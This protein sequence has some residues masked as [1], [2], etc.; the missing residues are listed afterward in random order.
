MRGST[1]PTTSRDRSY[2]VNPLVGGTSIGR[3]YS[4]VDR[5]IAFIGELHERQRQ[6]WRR[7]DDARRRR[8]ATARPRLRSRGRR[9]RRAARVSERPGRVTA[10]AQ[11]E[12]RNPGFHLRARAR[13]LD[14]P[15]VPHLDCRARSATPSFRK[16]GARPG[17]PCSAKVVERR[18]QAPFGFWTH[19]LMRGFEGIS[20]PSLCR[21]FLILGEAD[22]G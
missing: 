4:V 15:V 11:T 1:L 14:P 21:A 20:Y 7:S 17:A 9:R 5:V 10:L 3:G 6:L 22:S 19:R 16:T 13:G 12:W 18:S 8:Q 2:R